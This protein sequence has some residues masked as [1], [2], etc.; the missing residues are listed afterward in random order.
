MTA[1]RLIIETHPVWQ[2]PAS[3]TTADH[4]TS[5]PLEPSHSLATSQT[6]YTLLGRRGTLWHTIVPRIEQTTDALDAMDTANRSQLFDRLVVA[7]AKGLSGQPLTNWETFVCAVPYTQPNLLA[8]PSFADLLRRAERRQTRHPPSDPGP[9][10]TAL[11]MTKNDASLCLLILLAVALWSQAA[12]V[13]LG[14]AALALFETLYQQDAFDRLILP[15]QHNF[16]RMARLYLYALCAGLIA[17]P[18]LAGVMLQILDQ[19]SR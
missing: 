17:I 13:L 11:K 4:A 8:K 14:V 3:D 2:K 18:L 6:I 5:A 16:I 7:C 10:L 15:P 1:L 19:V 9:T 12:P